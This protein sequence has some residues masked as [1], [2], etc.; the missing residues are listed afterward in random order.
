MRFEHPHLLWLLL[1]IVPGVILF[2]WWAQREKRR[3]LE[4]IINPRL[5]EQ[6]AAGI[7]SRLQTLR[8]YLWTAAAALLVISFARP[9]WGFDWEEIRQHGLDIVVAIDTSRSMLAEDVAPNRLT[10]AK[11][12]ALDLRKLANADR[13]GLIAFAGTAFLQCP[14]SSDDEAFQQSVNELNVNIIPQGGTALAEA[15]ETARAAFK[16]KTDNHH[17]LVLFTDGEDHDGNAVET[18]KAVAKEGLR[19]FTVGVGTP[20]GELLRTIDARGRSEY[21]KDSEGHVVKSGL[22]KGLLTQ[23]AEATQGFYVPLEGSQTIDILYTRGLAPLPKGDLGARQVKRYHERFQ[24]FLCAAL[25]LLLAEMFLPERKRQKATAVRPVL[26]RAAAVFLFFLL[27]LV[28][29]AASAG[30]A[31]KDYSAGKYERALHQYQ[32]LLAKKPADPKLNFNAGDAAFQAGFYDKALKHFNSSLA[33]EDLALQ[34]QS[35]YNL[36]NAHYRLGEEGEDPSKKQGNWEQA[37]NSYESA[38]K[39]NPNDPD[40]KHNLE[41]VKKKLEELKQQQQQQNKDGDK[42]DKEDKDKQD[43]NKQDPN[44]QDQ[45]DNQQQQQDQQKQD[46]QNQDQ[47]KQQDKDQQQ[48]QQ[49]DQQQQKPA[50]QQQA[51]QQKPDDKKN[52]QQASKQQQQPKPGEEED[53]DQQDGQE[54]GKQRKIQMTPQQAMRLLEAMKNEERTL[55]FA[56]PNKTNRPPN[57]IFKDW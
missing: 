37:I 13:M 9:Q 42:N 40:A 25:V 32:D 22:N 10:R 30:K 16:Q 33:T 12:A 28:S 29:H 8:C 4:R 1:L 15:I 51:K 45:K 7:S 36:G 55:I 3:L 41:F 2:F 26:A 27:P 54:P 46:Q 35:F 57:R 5:F 31:S 39:L 34:E 24:W 52:D 47:Q 50:D 44:K 53:Q 11:L 18:A 17:V 43:Q 23:I 38:L 49:Q 56:P 6:L 20:N 19:I 48:Q 21:I 14:L